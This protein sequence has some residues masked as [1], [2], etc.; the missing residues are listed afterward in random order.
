MDEQERREFVDRPLTAVLSTVDRRG[1]PHAVP[2]WYAY[3]DGAFEIFTDRGSQK[4]RNVEATGRAAIC[5]DER[6]GGYRHITGEGP[7]EVQDPVTMEER[8][9]LHR[10]YRTEEA[11]RTIVERGG[12]EH[13]VV[14]RLR[15]ERW[16]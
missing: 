11:A 13:M 16:Y 10:L 12:H 5:I 14:L 7:C 4:H 6:E 15:P 8:L 1:R 9:A 2:V 3:R